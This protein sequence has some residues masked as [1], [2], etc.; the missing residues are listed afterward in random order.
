MKRSL[1]LHVLCIKVW[2][3]V[4][5]FGTWVQLKTNP[6]NPKNLKNEMVTLPI[7]VQY[8]SLL[9]CCTRPKV[10]CLGLSVLSDVMRHV[11]SEFLKLA[12]V[13]AF[14]S[15]SYVKRQGNS[16]AHFLART[17]KSGCELQVWQNSVS[18]DI[19]PLVTRDFL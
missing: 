12:S 17:S 5:N 14:Y 1:D 10:K 7:Y 19:A 3:F 9:N 13:F 11:I 15:F 2:G 6:S 16:V 8:Y 18:N 4:L